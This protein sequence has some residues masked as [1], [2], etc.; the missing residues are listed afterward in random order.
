[1][2]TRV[3]SKCGIENDIEEFPLRSQLT[4]RRQSYCK[5]CKSVMHANWYQRNKDYQ[6]ENARK[7]TA[8]YRS[9]I[10]E[11]LWSYLL[12]HPCSSCG[13]KDPV[14]LNSIIFTVRTWR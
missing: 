14:Y 9:A 12:T 7:H 11:Y 3:C 8:E 5:D 6:K 10:R 4:S 1:M 2:T 13:E